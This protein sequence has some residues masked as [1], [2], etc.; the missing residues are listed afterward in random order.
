[1]NNIDAL[2]LSVDD[3]VSSTELHDTWLELFHRRNEAKRTATRMWEQWKDAPDGSVE[4]DRLWSGVSVGVSG[5]GRL[6]GLVSYRVGVLHGRPEV[7]IPDQSFHSWPGF[8]VHLM[9]GMRTVDNTVSPE[10]F[11]RLWDDYV[12]ASRQRLMQKPFKGVNIS[13]CRNQ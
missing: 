7:P 13:A 3:S 12:H 2:H 9:K 1:M 8:G 6:D 4:A 11:A 5:V 10:L